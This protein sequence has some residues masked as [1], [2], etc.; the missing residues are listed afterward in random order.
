[1]ILLYYD[2]LS[3]CHRSSFFL[4]IF[5]G[6]RLISSPKLP[7]INLKSSG[8]WIMDITGSDLSNKEDPICLS[9]LFYGNLSCKKLPLQVT[10]KAIQFKVLQPFSIERKA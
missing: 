10:G 2:I 3:C 7:E 9:F 5:K 6:R 4:I 8:L 1:M